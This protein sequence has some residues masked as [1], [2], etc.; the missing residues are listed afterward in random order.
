MNSQQ[1]QGYRAFSLDLSKSVIYQ[2]SPVLSPQAPAVDGVGFANLYLRAADG[3]LQPLITKAPPH[4]T[5][6]QHCITA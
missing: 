3:D 1:G 2:I 6:G 5:P 4:R